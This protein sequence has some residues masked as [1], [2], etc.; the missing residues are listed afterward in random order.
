MRGDVRRTGGSRTKDLPKN[1]SK[2]CTYKSMSFTC[3]K[4][5]MRRRKKD[6]QTIE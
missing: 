2:T 1:K 3:G 5:N 6:L 4:E